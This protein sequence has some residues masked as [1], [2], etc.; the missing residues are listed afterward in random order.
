VVEHL[1]SE[2]KESNIIES[3]DEPDMSWE[4]VTKIAV[5]NFNNR[6]SHLSES[7]M[8]LVKILTSSND[9]KENFLE[10]LKNETLNRIKELKISDKDNTRTFELYENKIKNIN[11]KNL[12]TLDE[13]IISCSELLENLK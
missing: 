12:S 3:E 13:A 2:K 9:I 1:M 4:Y 11:S 7:D 10:D 5:S 8:K 6:Y